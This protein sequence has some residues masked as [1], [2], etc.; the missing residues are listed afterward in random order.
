MKSSLPKTVS[1]SLFSL[2]RTDSYLLDHFIMNLMALVSM[3]LTL[4]ENMT[5]HILSRVPVTSS[6]SNSS[7]D[8]LKVSTLSSE[9]SFNFLFS[10][11]SSGAHL[12][13]EITFVLLVRSVS[14]SCSLVKGSNVHR[15][16]LNSFL[17]N[18]VSS[19]KILFVHLVFNE[20]FLSKF[21]A[22]LL[23]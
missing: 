13:I 18:G 14:S 22:V 2:F 1:S 21:N 12:I 11:E 16:H 7:A 6:F 8:K 3:T 19:S 4:T 23:F 15:R 17:L 20:G 5:E 9:G 10:L